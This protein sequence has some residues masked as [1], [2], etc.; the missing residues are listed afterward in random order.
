MTFLVNTSHN[1]NTIIEN[2]KVVFQ[3]I[4]SVHTLTI[5]DPRYGNFQIRRLAY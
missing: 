3:V 4:D 1:L 2:V 5:Q